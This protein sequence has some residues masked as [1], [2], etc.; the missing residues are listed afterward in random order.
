MRKNILIVLVVMIT[1]FITA[2]SPES[3]EV[4]RVSEQVKIGALSGPTG[5]GMVELMSEDEDKYE[6]EIFNAPDQIVG[7]IVNG[8]VDIAAVPTNLASTLYNRTE[9]ELTFI[10]V[11]TLGMLSIVESGENISSIE[12]LNGKDVVLAGKGATPEFVLR[13]VVEELGLDTNLEF[14]GD[15][16]DAAALLASGEKEVALLPQPFTTVALSNNEN[17]R[18]ALDMNDVWSDVVGEEAILPMGAVIVRN[19]FLEEYPDSVEIF[20]DDY[21]KSVE[22]VNNNVEDASGLVA[23]YEII[24]SPKEVLEVAIPQCN[25]TFIDAQEAKESVEQLYNVFFGFEPSSVGGSIPDEEFYYT[26]DK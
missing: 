23:E 14:V 1:T 16:A 21:K 20:I 11:N 12:D 7:K 2:C 6:V 22:Y 19:E 26:E 17:L 9:G 18:I 5:I 25:I 24:N 15:N 4:E 8:E 13:Y 3:N 10:G